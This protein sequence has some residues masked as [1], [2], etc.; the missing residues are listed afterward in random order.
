MNYFYIN[1]RT[2]NDKLTGLQRLTLNFIKHTTLPYQLIRPK[3]KFKSTVGSL[4]EQ[5]ILPFRL[6]NKRLLYCPANTGPILYS[7]KIVLIADIAPIEHPEWFNPQF[8]KWFK[9][10]I[11]GIIKTSKAIITISHYSKERIIEK[12]GHLNKNIYVAYLGIEKDFKFD[13][14]NELNP[15]DVPKD[16]FLFVGSIDPRKNIKLLI[17]TWNRKYFEN[18][19]LVIVGNYHKN[20]NASK[21][22]NTKNITVL[23]NINDS[24]L[25]TIYQ[26]AK[27]L[28]YPSLYEGFAFPPLEALSLGTP[29]ICSDIQVFREILGD[30]VSYV[31]PH[32]SEDL[33]NIIKKTNFIS[34]KN[35][36]SRIKDEIFDKYSWSKSTRTIESIITRYNNNP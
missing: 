13:E 29:V 22:D 8:A 6:K 35:N 23:N 31:N 11:P 10:V 36:V 7:N 30:F 16:Y 20:F 5:F 14:S 18:E 27:C 26:N 19:N 34:F 9:M 24:Q 33:E 1:V 21:V 25:R 17:E 12:Y 28:I 4:W 3:L 2:L 32:S 15:T